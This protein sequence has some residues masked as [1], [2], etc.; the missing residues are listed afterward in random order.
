[1]DRIRLVRATEAHVADLAPR[2]RAE[3]EAETFRECGLTGPHALRI[4]FE[5]STRTWALVADRTIC[6][7]GITP[8][9]VSEGRLL[10]HIGQPWCM[11][12]PDVELY[13]IAYVKASRIVVQE[14]LTL[15]PRLMTLVDAQY[16][17]ALRW[18]GVV[19]F[20]VDPDSVAAGIHG[21]PFRFI[22]LEV[23]IGVGVGR[24]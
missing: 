24:G 8:F 19:G 23:P 22:E 11:T 2:L 6:I 16:A 13:P 17:Q 7:A 15:F 3:D 4:S 12:S 18:A 1:M 14:M 21:E 10:E 20:T 9:M 5:R